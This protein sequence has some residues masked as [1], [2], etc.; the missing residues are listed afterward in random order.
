VNPG[1]DNGYEE[2]VAEIKE[3][4]KAVN[5]AEAIRVAIKT[6]MSKNILIRKGYS[7]ADI[8]K[9]LVANG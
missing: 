2:F 6:C 7:S 5:L 4:L 8:E 3:N 9:F 1:S